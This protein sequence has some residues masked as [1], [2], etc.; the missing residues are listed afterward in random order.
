MR[1]RSTSVKAHPVDDVEAVAP[2]ATNVLFDIWLVSRATAGLLDAVLAPT[3]LSADEFGVYSALTSADSL[4]PTELARWMSAPPTTVSSYVRRLIARGHLERERNPSDGR[5]FDLRL[6][7]AGRAAHAAAGAR[8][9][10]ALDAVVAALGAHQPEVRRA[11]A[12][13]RHSLDEVILAGPP[14]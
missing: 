4:T 14:T 8:F 1:D 10:P 11:L 13:L 6:T 3:G 7:E 12:V 5:S 9:L 2:E